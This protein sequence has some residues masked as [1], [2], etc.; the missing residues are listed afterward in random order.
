MGIRTWLGR[1]ALGTWLKL[2]ALVALVLAI[3]LPI[4]WL[5]EPDEI[6]AYERGAPKSWSKLRK[7]RAELGK[8]AVAHRWVSLSEVP[9]DVQLAVV[10]GEDVGFLFHDGIELLEMQQAVEDWW[11][12]GDELR[13]ASTITQQLAKNL[14]LSEERS[15]LRK[16]VEARYA[17]WLEKR[18]GKRRILE[19]YLNIVELAP[20]TLGVDAGARH[21]FG[22]GVGQLTDD[23]GAQ[24]AATIPSPLKHNPETKSRAWVARYNAIQSR[25]AQYGNVRQRL[26]ALSR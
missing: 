17:Y 11:E 3:G 26:A 1:R 20:G 12:H 9:V 8:R 18:L 23:Q 22:V 16:L 25:M 24:L 10:T 15:F 2:A 14:F 19:L 6:A 13:G 21:Y 7:E 5:R 4:W